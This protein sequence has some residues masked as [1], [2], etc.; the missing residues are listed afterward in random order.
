MKFKEPHYRDQF[1]QLPK[2]LQEVALYFDSLC[3]E[4]GI[5]PVVTRCWDAVAGDSG[6]HEAHRAIDFRDEFKD[7]D[8]HDQRTFCDEQV[9][10]LTSAINTMYPRS[11][12]KLVCIHHSFHGMPYHFHLQI[13]LAWAEEK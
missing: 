1:N 10:F 2:K 11:D 6:V 3:D 13:P 8:G 5:D 7:G 9:N 12:G 4:M